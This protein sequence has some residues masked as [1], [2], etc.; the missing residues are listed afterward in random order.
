[1]K[2]VM[3]FFRRMMIC[4]LWLGVPSHLP[5]HT[6]D[7]VKQAFPDQ[8]ETVPPDLLEITRL[9]D[10]SAGM[11]SVRE[12]LHEKQ[13]R[14]LLD[15][16]ESHIERKCADLLDNIPKLDQQI[17][18]LRDQ[19]LVKEEQRLREIRDSAQAFIAVNCRR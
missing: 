17:I 8:M 11:N 16:V 9:L 15:H 10:N 6:L 3:Q 7:E 14:L 5:A 2:S 4:L 13:H 18:R 19:A 1:M 12:E